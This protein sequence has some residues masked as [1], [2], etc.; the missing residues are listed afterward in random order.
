M[1]AFIE[2]TE[3]MTRV[4]A[5]QK[6]TEDF[7]SNVDAL[8]DRTIIERFCVEIIRAQNILIS[9]LALQIVEANDLL[10]KHNIKTS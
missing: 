1:S 9:T 2:N 7:L 4:M 3:F 8:P 5:S 10:H 6:N